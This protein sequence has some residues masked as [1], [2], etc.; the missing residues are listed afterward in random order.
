MQPAILI[1]MSAPG[2][3]VA[4]FTSWLTIPEPVSVHGGQPPYLI[5]YGWIPVGVQ[6][7]DAVG[8]SQC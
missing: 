1:D 2:S 5:V 6:D 7:D 3:Q 8:L 4:A